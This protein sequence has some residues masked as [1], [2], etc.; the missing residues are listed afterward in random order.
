MC[1]ST[2]FSRRR[3][4]LE[5]ESNDSD[6]HANHN[7]VS[8]ESDLGVDNEIDIIKDEKRTQRSTKETG[9]G[10]VVEMTIENT[11]PVRDNLGTNVQ[12][13]PQRTK[14]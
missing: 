8:G 11:Q 4:L 6:D 9:N 14:L 10:D 3:L 1:N 7:D 12:V 5:D 13:T 2:H